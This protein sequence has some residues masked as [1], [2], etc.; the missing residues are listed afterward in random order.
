M[1]NRS[2]L[3]SLFLCHKTT[4]IIYMIWG[5]GLKEET[6]EWVCRLTDPLVMMTT[7]MV[8]IILMMTMRMVEIILR[9][10]CN[11]RLGLC[12]SVQEIGI[13]QLKSSYEKGYDDNEDDDD[14]DDV[15][16]DEYHEND[17]DRDEGG[18]NR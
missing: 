1:C 2:V 17:D 12:A 9:N 3:I 10:D 15:D 4:Q 14:D 13:W 18:R 11:K 6:R 8:N 5:S 16:D 7:N